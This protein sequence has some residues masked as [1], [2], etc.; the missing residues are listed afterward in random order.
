MIVAVAMVIEPAI[1]PGETGTFKFIV[2]VSSPSTMSSSITAMFTVLLLVPAVIIAV[3][4][5]ELKST[6]LPVTTD[7]VLIVFCDNV[8]IKCYSV[9]CVDH[10]M[11]VHSHVLLTLLYRV[12]GMTS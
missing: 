2:N 12:A 4:I 1:I 7:K 10:N 3:C 6:L 8:R 9:L 5:A 11:H